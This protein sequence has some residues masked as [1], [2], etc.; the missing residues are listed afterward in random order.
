[1]IKNCKIFFVLIC[2]CTVLSGCTLTRNM[3]DEYYSDKEQCFLNEEDITLFNYKDEEYTILN[4]TVANNDLGGWVGYVRQFVVVN[5]EGKILLQE[6]IENIS[7]KNLSNLANTVPEAKYIIPFLNIYSPKK[8]SNHLIIEVNG[9]YHKAIPS[10]QV[11][12]QDLKLD[13]RSD[14]GNDDNN[15]QINPQNATQL[16]S[17]NKI[18]QVTTETITR[19]KLGGYLDVLAK[20]VVFDE[21][22]KHPLTQEELN[23]ISWSGEVSHRIQWFY[24]E[25]YEISGVNIDDAIAVKINN[26]YY[27]AKL[28]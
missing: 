3:I 8:D 14:K 26:Q 18:Y 5:E 22:N 2:V 1:M 16:I 24:S 9:S 28:Q 12:D 27:I 17:N 19:E 13:F 15:Y 4:D 6:N 20:P 10:E 7:F 21:D 11:T 23:K 25:I